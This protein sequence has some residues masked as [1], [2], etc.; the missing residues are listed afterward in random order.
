MTWRAQGV[1]PRRG[2]SLIELMVGSVV[3]TIILG[4]VAMTVLAVQNSYQTESRINVAVEGARTA[5]SFIEQRLRMAGYGVDPRFAFDVS[6]TGLDASNVKSNQKLTLAPGLPYSVTD[7]LAFRYRDPAWLRRGTFLGSSLRLK[8]PTDTFGTDL[9]EGQRVM[10]ACTDGTNYLVL[11]VKPGG[12][13]RTANVSANFSVD[14]SLSSP[15][16]QSTNPCLSKTDPAAPMVML[17]HE[18]RVRIMP[19]DGRPFLMAF[20]NLNNLNTANAVPLAADVE[21]FQVAYVM[22]RPAPGSAFASLTAVDKESKPS[23]WVLGDVGSDVAERLP[24]TTVAAPNYDTPYEH[25][26]RYNAH[27][28]N[29]R[30]VRLSITVRSTR[31][32]PKR[33]RAFLRTDVEDSIENQDP[34]GAGDGFYRTTITTMVRVPNML[35]RASF[36]PFLSEDDTNKPPGADSGGLAW[37]G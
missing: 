3:T 25:A 10:V 20:S 19:L 34:R 18:V 29:I 9:T 23:N 13:A 8:D 27:P 1:Q 6:N 31:E 2:F 28:A 16:M 12:V 24:I 30:A 5:T 17:L 33:R 22:N 35:S 26:W 4:A 36:I 37:G 21:S 11:Q 32:E 14:L 15:G 7:D